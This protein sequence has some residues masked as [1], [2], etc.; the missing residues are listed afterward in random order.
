MA[1]RLRAVVVGC[2]GISN[3]WMNSRAVKEGAEVVG[4]VDLLGE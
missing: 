3:A 1:A 2:G 4:V